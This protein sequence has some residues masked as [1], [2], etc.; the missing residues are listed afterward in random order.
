MRV[1]L[2]TILLS[3]A[4]SAALTTP[5]LAQTRELTMG[6]VVPPKHGTT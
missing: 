1:P 5:V 4:L 2:R 6:T 3:L